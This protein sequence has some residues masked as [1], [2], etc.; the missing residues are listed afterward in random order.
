MDTQCGYM[1]IQNSVDIWVLR[2][3]SGYMSTQ[4]GYMGT[5]S[6]YMGTQ[7]SMGM[8]ILRVGKWIFRTQWIYGHSELRVG[9]WVL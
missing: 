6:G 2:A 3:Q 7:N 5:Q 4:S 9:I 1:G 8:G